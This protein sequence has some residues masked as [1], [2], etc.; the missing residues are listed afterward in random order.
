MTECSGQ[1][2]HGDVST[3]HKSVNKIKLDLHDPIHP[4]THP[5]THTSTHMWKVSIDHKSANIIKLSKLVQE[6][7]HLIDLKPPSWGWMGG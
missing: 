7:F 4:P 1:C 3:D 6:L 5:P 2:M